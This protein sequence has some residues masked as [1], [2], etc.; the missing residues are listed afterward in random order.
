MTLRPSLTYHLFHLWNSGLDLIYP[1][2]CAGCESWG[3]HWCE[4]CQRNV[5]RVPLPHCEICGDTVQ[6]GH[7]CEDCAKTRPAFEALRSC[8]VFK[9]P[10]RAALHRLKYK[11]ETSL[12]ESL[13]WEMAHY[14]EELAWQIDLVVPIPLSDARRKE[15]G[16][17]QAEVLS[18]PLA[19][20]LAKTHQPAA[21]RRVQHTRSQVGLGLAER[22]ENV[23]NAF[24]AERQ[25]A[26]G[27]IILLI[28]DVATTGSTLSSASS[29]LLQ[30]GARRVYCLT[31]ARAVQGTDLDQPAKG[32]QAHI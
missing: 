26:A 1:P 19:A 11:Q 3:Q 31:L 10:V 15:R 16:Y 13:A 32:L 6:N 21:L 17:N 18:Q 28:D 12:G 2:R 23:Q 25:L 24:R 4:K 20:I 29:A 27:K 22:R 30:A 14:F 5:E 9:Q 8:F 7:L